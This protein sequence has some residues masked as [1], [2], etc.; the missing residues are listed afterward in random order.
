MSLSYCAKLSGRALQ[1]SAYCRRGVGLA[2]APAGVLAGAELGRRRQSCAG[3]A[4]AAVAN[5]HVTLAARL[6]I[7]GEGG[8]PGHKMEAVAAAAWGRGGS[9]GRDEVA[10]PRV[11]RRSL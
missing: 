5:C 2:V 8:E 7:A 11:A 4:C 10:P 1:A 9:P 6:H 3:C